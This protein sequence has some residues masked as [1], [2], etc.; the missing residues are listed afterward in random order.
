MPTLLLSGDYD[1]ITPPEYAARLMPHLARG[2]HVVFPGGSHGQAMTGACANGIIA[3]FL[4]DPDA[5]VDTT[6]VGG[7]T[8]EFKTPGD[9]IFLDTAQG[10]LSNAGIVG[11]LFIGLLW[12][13]AIL[14]GL[15]LLTAALVYPVGYLVRLV[16]GRVA[17][18]EPGEGL[19]LSRAAPWLAV[20]A[21]MLSLG[22]VGG[23]AYAYGST[24]ATNETLAAMGAI[25]SGWRWLLWLP[26]ILGGAAAVMVAATVSLWRSGRRSTL[27]RV[28]FTLLTIAAVAAAINLWL[29]GG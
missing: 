19:A 8:P 3:G 22:F 20:A 17:E 1:P 13:P 2:Q 18:S 16:R 11:L 9:V 4:D 24:F 29:V 21:G 5:P 25:S 28:Y 7:A 12:A 27:G 15:L 10:M 23:L 26:P 14:G 6:C